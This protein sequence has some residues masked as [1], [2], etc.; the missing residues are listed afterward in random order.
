MIFSLGNIH[1]R[2]WCWSWHSNTL[3]TWCEKLT[4]LKRP[5]CWERFRAGGEGDDRGCDGWNASPTQW[6]WV[7]WT[8]GV[9][10]GQVGLVCCGSW[11]RKESDMTEQ[12]NWTRSV[13]ISVC[14][15]TI[16]ENCKSAWSQGGL[17]SLLCECHLTIVKADVPVLV[18][19]PGQVSQKFLAFHLYPP[20]NAF[21]LLP[22]FHCCLLLMFLVYY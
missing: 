13:I 10:D 20:S 18:V 9:G 16:V 2:D 11:G 8:P 7:W 22:A 4:R 6:T 15:D 12:L 3:A 1:W 21:S 19:F 14:R 17:R 5:W